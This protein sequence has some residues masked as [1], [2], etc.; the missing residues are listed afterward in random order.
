MSADS[1][2]AL[3]DRPTVDELSE[4]KRAL[5]DT[6]IGGIFDIFTGLPDAI[7][8]MGLYIKEL[9]ARPQIRTPETLSRDEWLTLSAISLK[10]AATIPEKSL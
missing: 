6:G 8:Q 7:T 9:E 1:T 3:E 10:L 5:K 4:A 2:K